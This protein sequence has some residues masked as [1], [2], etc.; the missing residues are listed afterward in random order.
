MAANKSPAAE[1]VSPAQIVADA[2]REITDAEDLVAALEQRV[3][4]G[5]ETVDA[6]QVEKARGL[7]RFA[8]LRKAAAEKKAAALAEQLAADEFDAFVKTHLDGI[9]A[10]ISDA[11]IT[12]EL[13]NIVGM[14]RALNDRVM[15]RNRHVYALARR[16]DPVNTFTETPA[17]KA[18]VGY[19][20]AAPE[21]ARF[22][23]GDRS[24]HVI[25]LRVLLQ[26]IADDLS[27]RF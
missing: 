20:S 26:R 10:G 9:D 12:G 21:V 5:D 4:D 7:A 11:E 16:G 27:V 2:D 3:Q 19:G 8:Q 6:D 1:A 25:P 18:L 15:D 24:G 23:F 14:I 22:T 17:A 13:Q